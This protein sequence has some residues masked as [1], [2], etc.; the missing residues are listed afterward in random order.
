MTVLKVID[1]FCGVGGAT[2]GFREAGFEVVLAVDK[3]GTALDAYSANHPEVE[4]W[5]MDIRVLRAEN[6]PEAD[7][8]LGST[9]CTSFSIANRAR[10]CDMTLTTH[11]L[12]I[13]AKY[14]P[15]Y[16]MLENV[17]PL[18][19][20][21]PKG[22]PYNILNVADYG[23]PQRRKRCFAG[24]Y[25]RPE[26]THSKIPY[27]RYDN[28]ITKPWN[29]FKTIQYPDGARIISKK[30][31]AGAFR[32][33]NQL[34]KKGYRFDLQFIGADDIVPTICASSYYGLKA[35][36]PIVWEA[37]RLRQLSWLECVRAQSFPDLYIFSGTQKQKYHQMGNA[38]PPLMAQKIAEEIRRD[39]R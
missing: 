37:G 17:P 28:T 23:V 26:E 1:L 29:T 16:W 11:F 31:I 6:L 13:I 33:A 19:K 35:S 4:T 25:P 39:A 12:D 38:V 30:G 10:T 27:V 32:R 7:V 20:H 21:L 5:A 15:R 2:L 9:P 34:G 3:D 36:S 22:T 18:A 24:N 14:S 8:I